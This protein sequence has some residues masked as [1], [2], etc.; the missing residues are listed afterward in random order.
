[1]GESG[2]YYQE[3]GSWHLSA[4]P[5][6]ELGCFSPILLCTYTENP[7]AAAKSHELGS[8]HFA[9]N[10]ILITHRFEMYL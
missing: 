9:I 7:D 5:I 6:D 2:N 4:A 3:S 10:E 1:M 8:L